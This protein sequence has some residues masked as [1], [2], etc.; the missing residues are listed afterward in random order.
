[1]Y[2]RHYI[3][4]YLEHRLKQI[5]YPDILLIYYNM[6]SIRLKLQPEVNFMYN[7]ILWLITY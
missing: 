3:I 1:M 5:F 2:T 6:T 4:E 7:E